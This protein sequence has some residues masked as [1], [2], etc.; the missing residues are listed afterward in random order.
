[1]FDVLIES[2]HRS[3]RKRLLSTG[4]V[5]VFVHLLIL[6]GAVWA[7]YGAAEASEE[8]KIDTTLV[9][10]NPEQEKPREPDIAALAPPPKG[11]QTVVAPMEIPTNIPPVNLQEHFDPRDYSGEGVEGGI[12][13]GTGPVDQVFMEAVVEERPERLTSPPLVYPEMLRQAG[14]QGTVMLQ[15]IIDTTGHVIASSV[16]ILT[17]PNP[18]FNGPARE[19][20][21]KSLF[22]PARVRGRP[23][24]V[25]IQIPVTFTITRR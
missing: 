1:M 8:T 5:S 10:L 23:V 12:A 22:R 3:S 11:F 19:L 6:A 2:K 13:T 25:L 9:F 4:S 18:G 16:K 17:S 15:A 7:T 24:K 14:I 20:L 21:V